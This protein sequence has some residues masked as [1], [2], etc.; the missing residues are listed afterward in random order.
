MVMRFNSEMVRLKEAVTRRIKN[1]IARFNSEMVRLKDF[2]QV[3]RNQR[4]FS[5]NSEMV[6][7]KEN[8]TGKEKGIQFV[9]IPKWFD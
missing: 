1:E 2:F 6:R 7:L 5:F 9:S 4:I 3:G 8:G